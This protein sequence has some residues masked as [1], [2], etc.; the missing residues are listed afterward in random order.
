MSLTSIEHAEGL[1]VGNHDR[2]GTIGR[3]LA[4]ET[5]NLVRK[6]AAALIRSEGRDIEDLS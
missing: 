4:P 6:R 3:E 2:K 5:A 1:G